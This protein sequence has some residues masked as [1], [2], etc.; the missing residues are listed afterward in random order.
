[1]YM[2]LWQLYYMYMYTCI[3]LLWYPMHTPGV[4]LCENKKMKT[5]IKKDKQGKGRVK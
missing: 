1:M 2:Y 3:S 5:G 4:F